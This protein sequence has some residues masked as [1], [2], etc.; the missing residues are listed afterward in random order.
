MNPANILKIAYV[1]NILILVPTCWS[2][3]SA[4]GGQRVF[5][6]VVNESTGLR[7]RCCRLSVTP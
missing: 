2:M 6:G 7:A 5:E 1:A 3:F 4:A